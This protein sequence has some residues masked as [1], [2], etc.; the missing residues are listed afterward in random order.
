MNKCKIRDRSKAEK[1]NKKIEFIPPEEIM[2]VILLVL[3]NEYGISKD[4]LVNK[5]AKI[6]GY[7]RTSEQIFSV[8]SNVISK[9]K[10][11]G[12]ENSIT[13]RVDGKLILK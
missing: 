4:D 1:V 8:I 10:E 7:N 13:E 9:Y 12:S 2:E 11:Y 5:V 3:S 6:L